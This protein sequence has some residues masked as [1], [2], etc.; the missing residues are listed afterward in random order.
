M[1]AELRPE[2]PGS[3]RRAIRRI[4]RASAKRGNINFQS[5]VISKRFELNTRFWSIFEN[6]FELI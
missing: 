5:A 2:A 6:L 1:T 3:M 4:A